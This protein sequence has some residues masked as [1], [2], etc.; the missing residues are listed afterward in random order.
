MAFNRP[1]PNLKSK[2]SKPSMD[3]LSNAA[4]GVGLQTPT[5]TAMPSIGSGSGG[6]AIPLG[7]SGATLG[8]VP[9]NQSLPGTRPVS[10]TKEE[11]E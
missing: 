9:S 10:T 2:Q 3:D 4:T 7:G 5:A 1:T 6:S 11:G 8:G